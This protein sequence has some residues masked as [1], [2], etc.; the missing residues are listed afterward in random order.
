MSENFAG[1]AVES[2]ITCSPGSGLA[3]RG[4]VRSQ[5][6]P[7]RG[8]P[9]RGVGVDQQAVGGVD[10]AHRLHG[11]RV[12]HRA[13]LDPRSHVF[14]APL[15][16]FLQSFEVARIAHVHGVGKR[17]RG[18]PRVERAALQVDRHHVVH[19]G[20]GNEPVDGKSPPPRVDA[21]G[22]VAEVAAGHAERGGSR[23]RAPLRVCRRRGNTG[24]GG[25]AVRC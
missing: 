19:V 16:D 18:R 1:W 8:E 21:R 23:S 2:T 15:E 20:R 11:S 12:G 17:L 5:V 4:A 13:A 10:F 7:R 9:D 22:E 14:P 24:T 3:T 25:S 6:I